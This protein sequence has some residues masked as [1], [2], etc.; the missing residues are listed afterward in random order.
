[1]ALTGMASMYH[2][3][4]R[5]QAVL[6]KL[7]IRIEP[8]RV[9]HEP[10]CIGNH[11]ISGDDGVTFNSAGPSDAIIHQ[12]PNSIGVNTMQRAHTTSIFR[13]IVY[14]KS[15]VEMEQKPALATLLPSQARRIWI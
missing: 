5:V 11:A 2:H 14:L 8:E 3:V 1:M 9:R 6:K 12:S 10:C 4:N 7:L 15:E 13:N